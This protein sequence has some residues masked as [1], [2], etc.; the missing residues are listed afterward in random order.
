ML[1]KVSLFFNVSDGDFILVLIGVNQMPRADATEY[2]PILLLQ[3]LCG[4]YILV[5]SA[6]AQFF[7]SASSVSPGPCSAS[8]F[9]LIRGGS[10]GGGILPARKIDTWA[11]NGPTKN[12]PNRDATTKA[13]A[14]YE[15]ME[16]GEGRTD[17]RNILPRCVHPL[18]ARVHTWSGTG[19]PAPGGGGEAEKAGRRC[20]SAET[21]RRR[22][23]KRG[24]EGRQRRR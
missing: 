10:R 6:H 23:E 3:P 4:L 21:R 24:V 14:Y 15:W 5:I 13:Y 17:A 11:S 16:P 2:I 19:D 12:G 1:Y 7:A 22:G 18:S 20:R 8:I 9:N